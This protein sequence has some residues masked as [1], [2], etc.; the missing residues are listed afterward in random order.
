MM[1]KRLLFFARGFNLKTL[2]FNLKYLPFTQAVKFPFFISRRCRLRT[3]KGEV[4]INGPIHP[5][6]II[7]GYG[8]VG[9]FDS[10]RSRSI[11]NVAGLVTFEGKANIGHGCKISVERGAE[12]R[13]GSNF[14]VSAETSIVCAKSIVIGS[15]C[16][17]SWEILVMDTDWHTIIN[18]KETIINAP[19]SI[20][21]GNHVWVGC[22]T[23]ILKGVHIE[24]N[25]I[26]AASSLISKSITC[27]NAIIGV[28]NSLRSIKENVTWR[29]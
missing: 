18:D 5:G 24:D 26:I 6:M 27:S 3:V 21:I 29:S 17:F 20:V 15:D 19:A 13:I 4:K 7:I 8:Q 25:N 16:L 14:M 28:E 22:R 23:T 1:V 9:I 10:K 11:W 12:L 2:Y